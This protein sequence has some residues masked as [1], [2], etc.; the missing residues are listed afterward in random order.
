MNN[1]TRALDT[2]QLF[3]VS[4]RPLSLSLPLF[5]KSEVISVFYSTCLI[6]HYDILPLSPLSLYT[7]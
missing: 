5:F 6:F 3:Y 2:P 1:E 7:N 4:Q